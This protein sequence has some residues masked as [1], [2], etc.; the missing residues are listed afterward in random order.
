MGLSFTE[1]LKYLRKKNGMSQRQLADAI[2]TSFSTLRRWESGERS[3][4]LQV[5]IR[6][7]EALDSSVAYL[8]GETDNPE[9]SKDMIRVYEGADGQLVPE[10]PKGWGSPPKRSKG[11]N[12]RLIR[13]KLVDVPVLAPQSSICCGKGFNLAEVEAEVDWWEPIPESWL[14][15]PKGDKPFFITHVEGDS[16]EPMIEDGERILVN[17]NQEVAHGDVAIVCWN[18]RSMVR[19]VKFERDGAVRL[20]PVN[21]D[22]DEDVISKE[23]RSFVL[24]FCGVVVRFLGKDR[25]S[26]GIL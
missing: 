17:P 10:Y 16:M 24:E 5:L 4:D 3:P 23:D 21:K 11:S 14:T 7:A 2:S 18:G 8:T 25:V 26:R 9:R 12:I 15:G 13:G 1:K 22:Y 20:V 6:I 19:G